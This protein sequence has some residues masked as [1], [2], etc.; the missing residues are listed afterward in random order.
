MITSKDLSECEEKIGNFFVM[1]TFVLFG[2]FTLNTYKINI[3]KSCI[4]KTKLI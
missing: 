1:Y 2:F 3:Y 4:F